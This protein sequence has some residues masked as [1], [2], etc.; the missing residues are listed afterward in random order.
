M[1]EHKFRVIEN[2]QIVAIEF[3]DPQFNEGAWCHYLMS[4]GG[5]DALIH[6]GV[7]DPIGLGHGFI[8]VYRE[9]YI[10]QH[11]KNDVEIYEGD[12]ARYTHKD[13]DYPIDFIIIFFEGVFVQD[14][15]KRH[16]PDLWYDWYD[17]EVIGNIRD[18][19]LLKG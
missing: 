10:E 12:I 14:N 4:E 7:Y 6:S 13:L 11:D 19:D 16:K 3:C 1:R 9:Q 18:K 5:E 2:E 15:E 8:K 17:L